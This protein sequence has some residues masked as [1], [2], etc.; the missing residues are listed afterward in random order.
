M[1]RT[2]GYGN[3]DRQATR[4]LRRAFRNPGDSSRA[5]ASSDDTGGVSPLWSWVFRDSLPRSSTCQYHCAEVLVAQMAVRHVSAGD[6]AQGHIQ[7][8][9]RLAAHVQGPDTVTE[10]Q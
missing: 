9:G 6:S 10:S 7:R 8:D 4:Q 2:N 1:L 5:K 3:V